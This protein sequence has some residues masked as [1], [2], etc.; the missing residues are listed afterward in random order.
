MQIAHFLFC[1]SQSMHLLHYPN[2]SVL[3]HLPPSVILHFSPSFYAHGYVAMW[4]N[5]IPKGHN[6]NLSMVTGYPL[7]TSVFH[8]SMQEVLLKK[9]NLPFEQN[10]SRL[11]Q[12]KYL[13][14]LKLDF[15]FNTILLCVLHCCR[16]QF[17]IR[18]K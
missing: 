18:L 3:M 14:H 13:S 9:Y 5:V 4:S 2:S 7:G 12:R 17:N 1:G 10:N 8:S 15:N 11:F 16:F 6:Y